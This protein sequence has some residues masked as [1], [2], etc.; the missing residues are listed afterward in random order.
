MQPSGSMLDVVILGGGIAGLWLL[1][2][3]RARGYAALLLEN[4]ALGAGQTLAS[5][6]IIH[7]GL[8]YAIDR[9]PG[10]ESATLADMPGR[11]RACM[12]G[13]GEIHLGAGLLAA[14]R[15]LFWTRR[16]LASRMA[17]FL[18]SKLVRGRAEAL[19][20]AAWPEALR[21]PAHIGAVYALDECVLDV[22]ALL[23]RLA[24]L[25]QGAVK[26]IHGP[27]Q[28][29]QAADHAV[30]DCVAAGGQPRRITARCVVAT[31]GAGNEALLAACGLAAGLAQRR[32]LQM[33]LLD[34]APV[35]LWA[36]CFDTSDKPRVTITSH[37]R[38]DGGLVWYIG[39]LLAEQGAGQNEAELIQAGRR[40]LAQLLPALDFSGCRY[41]GLPVD[42]AE[43]ATM[44]GRKPE[45]PVLHRVG[46]CLLAWPTKLALA[47]ALADQVLAQLPPPAAAA[48]P[49]YADWAAPAIAAAPWDR[50]LWQEAA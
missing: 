19:P 33:L 13:Q 49:D 2:R 43:G 44:D 10:Q 6:G 20:A 37:R 15:H 50:A 8:K 25:N 9:L 32:P 3:L 26:H 22:P 16:S 17:G 4:Q 34:H 30:L 27:A 31:A 29:S 36:H 40:E 28:L 7:G 11:W 45:G 35:P 24:A 5:Q 46:H 12:A 41:A 42:R 47:P 48:V 38:R 14:E 1:S 18:G 23:A 39:G 21:D